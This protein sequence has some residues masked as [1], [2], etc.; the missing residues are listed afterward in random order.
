MTRR[1]EIGRRDARAIY[2]S[3]CNQRAGYALIQVQQVCEGIFA[4][5]KARCGWGGGANERCGTR[6]RGGAGGRRLTF[7]HSSRPKGAQSE[8]AQCRKSLPETPKYP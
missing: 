7:R 3:F 4:T 6:A 1:K 8:I 5:V 2:R